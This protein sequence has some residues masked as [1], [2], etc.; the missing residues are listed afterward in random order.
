M[1]IIQKKLALTSVKKTVATEMGVS[2][3]VHSP[4]TKPI[5]HFEAT[6]SFIREK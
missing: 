6:L 5:T 2:V 4:S 3:F 1:P